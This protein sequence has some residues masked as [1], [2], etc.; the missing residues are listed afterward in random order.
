MIRL[1]RS[2]EWQLCALQGK[3]PGQGTTQIA[4]ATAPKELRLEWWEKPST[5]PTYPCNGRFC[6]PSGFTVGDVFFAEVAVAY[7]LCKNRASL[8]RLAAGVFFECTLDE[9]AFH[10][11]A[12]RIRHW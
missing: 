10:E 12:A 11:L 7:A 5:H 1:P 2:L 6:D 4:F 9:A 3:L 8:L